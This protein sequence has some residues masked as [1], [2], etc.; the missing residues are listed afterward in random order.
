VSATPPYS[1]LPADRPEHRFPDKNPLL[2]SAQA[3]DEA[4]R[5]VY[6][7]DAPCIQ[8]CPTSINISE[9]IRK[10]ATGN[11]RGAA[12]TILSANM[13]GLSCARVCP[14]EVLCEGDCVYTE[15]GRPPIEIGRLQRYAVE[16]A[17]D[18][19]IHFFE[20]GPSTGK[21]VALVGAGPASLACAH[22]LTRL[23]HEAVIFEGHRYPGGLNTTAVAPYKLFVEDALREVDYITQ[24]GIEIRYG[25]RVGSDVSFEQLEA[26]F[27]A[28]FLGMGL[29]GDGR[30][31]VE[32]HE[33]SGVTGAL[34]LIERM[35]LGG[36][37]DLSGVQKAVVI[38]AGN[39]AMDMVRELAGLGVPKVTLMY[40]RD[41]EGMSGYDHEWGAAK[42]AGV[43]WIW[44]AQPIGF[45]GTTHVTG[46]RY[47]SNRPG[48]GSEEHVVEAD[49]VAVAIGQEKH[50]GLL[51]Q[52]DGLDVEWGRIVV[53]ENQQTSKPNYFS[54]GD[55][56]NGGKEVV[57]A[58]A[59]GKRAAM[60]IDRYLNSEA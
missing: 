20:A 29:G 6:C 45:E 34:D 49:L 7:F 16:H 4:N 52:I 31:A 12:K 14:V 53:D 41:Q 32:G 23:G 13:L 38:G 3:I 8:I 60:S 9:F 24:I 27:D 57:N 26:E 1:R 50:T 36:E 2:T 18:R 28:F 35:K 42:G 22:E 33:L 15:M 58:A 59:E 39:T 43:E 37:F 54:G 44:W 5:C 19:D 21:R 51:S 47:V 55:C 25:T 10:I 40:R 46:V 11:T 17:Y 56:A 30:L 48:A